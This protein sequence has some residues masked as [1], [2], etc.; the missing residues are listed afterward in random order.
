MFGLVHG[1]GF[2]SSLSSIGLPHQE[3]PLS[4]FSFNLG[5]ELGQIIF[6]LAASFVLK[7]VHRVISEHKLDRGL[8]YLIGSVSSF[9]LFERMIF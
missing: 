7:I 1:F 8:A 6:I 5:I 3:I 9:W 2:S 4:L